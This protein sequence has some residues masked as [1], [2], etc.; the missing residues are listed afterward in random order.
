MLD[1][2]KKKTPVVQDDSKPGRSPSW[3]VY[4]RLD[5]A[6]QKPVEDY[7]AAQEYPPA[8]ARVIERALK[9]LLRENG[10]KSDD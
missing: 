1:M 10:R 7:I 9:L 4:A 8:L 3:V 6:L 5:P 2:A